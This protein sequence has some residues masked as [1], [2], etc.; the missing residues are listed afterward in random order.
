[1]REFYFPG[2]TRQRIP[3][4]L[5]VATVL[6]SV[7]PAVSTAA[8]EKANA[9]AQRTLDA[10]GGAEAW[11][12]TRFVR[13]NFFG[14]RLHHLDR[15]TG[16][17]RLEG[18][19]RSGEQYVVLHNIHSR[20]GRVFLDGKEA[21]GEAKAEWLERAYGAWVN[22]TYWLAMPYKLRDPGVHLSHDGEEEL[23]GQVYDKLLLTFDNGVGLTSGDRYWAYINRETGLMDR[24]AYFLEGYEEGQEPTHWQ[25]LDWKTCGGVKFSSR[26]VKVDSGDTREL[27]ELAVFD[28]LPDAVFESPAAVGE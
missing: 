8:D 14:F 25:W 7:L 12:A 18:K 17:H 2:I 11:Q 13:F 27:G 9:L 1:M 23:D 4:L 10:M 20:E 21:D 26:R 19:A 22:D 15:Q 28:E 16:R 24:W 3:G 6:V 5:L